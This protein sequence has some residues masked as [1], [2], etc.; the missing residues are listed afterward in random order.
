MDA[1]PDSVAWSVLA[2]H[3]DMATDMLR[4]QAPQDGGYG[5]LPLARQRVQSGDPVARLDDGES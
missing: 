4:W 5:C 3:S 2:V 1:A